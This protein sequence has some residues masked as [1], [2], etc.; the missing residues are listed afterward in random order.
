MQKTALIL[1][2]VVLLCLSCISCNEVEDNFN[3]SF[4]D[5][6]VFGIKQSSEGETFGTTQIVR[7]FEE[8]VQLCTTWNNSAFNENDVNYNS[9]LNTTLR[10]YDETYFKEKALIIYCNSRFNWKREPMVK[11]INVSGDELTV[12]ISIKKGTYTDIATFGTF[13]IE[14]DKTT[15][16]NATIIVTKESERR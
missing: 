12:E 2:T 15:L 9:E 5:T 11:S 14:L 4:Q 10:R 3:V 16:G 8:L 13:L 1:M 6:V 7:T